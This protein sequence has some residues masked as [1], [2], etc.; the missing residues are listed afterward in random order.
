MS[1]MNTLILLLIQIEVTGNAMANPAFL[2]EDPK[3][4]VEKVSHDLNVKPEQFTACFRNVNPAE[5]GSRPTSDRVHA[6]KTVLLSCLQQ[7]NPRITND[8]LDSVMDRYRPGGHE[9]Q[10]PLN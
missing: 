4:P 9:A 10:V 8:V 3:R 1:P 7:V 5:Q 6:N 2:P